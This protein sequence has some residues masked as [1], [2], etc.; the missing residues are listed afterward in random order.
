MRLEF[1][2]SGRKVFTSRLQ[3][4]LALFHTDQVEVESPTSNS[5]AREVREASEAGMPDDQIADV[6]VAAYRGA[7]ETAVTN[8]TLATKERKARKPIKVKMLKR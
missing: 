7:K 3:S 2:P 5:L 1:P 4:A 6:L 8:L